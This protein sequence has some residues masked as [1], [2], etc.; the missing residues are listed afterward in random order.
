MIHMVVS[1]LAALALLAGCTCETDIKSGKV[2]ENEGCIVYWFRTSTC[3]E[4]HYYTVCDAGRS[5]TTTQSLVC[6]R[7]KVT[8][9]CPETIPTEQVK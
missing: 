8:V 1:T 3:G 5:S 7:G 4:Y 6:H 9:P 2:L